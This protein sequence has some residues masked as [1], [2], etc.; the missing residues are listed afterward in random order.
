MDEKK[1]ILSCTYDGSNTNK[2]GITTLKF[3][4]PASEIAKYINVVMLLNSDIKAQIDNGDGSK[5]V[6]G[7][8][9]FKTLR[10]NREGDAVLQLESINVNF[11]LLNECFEKNVR[12]CLIAK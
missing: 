6:I 5:G 8:A 1:M 11:A 12:I 10:I 4:F 9:R 3:N 7:K 2:N